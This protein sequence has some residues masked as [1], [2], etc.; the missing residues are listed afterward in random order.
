MGAR[1][2]YKQE[3]IIVLYILLLQ[4]TVTIYNDLRVYYKL[5]V[6]REILL[7]AKTRSDYEF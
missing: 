6:S 4:D 5:L 2:N 7:T 1:M 3:Y